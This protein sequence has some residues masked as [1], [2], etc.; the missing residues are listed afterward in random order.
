MTKE[1]LRCSLQMLINVVPFLDH[2]AH[3]RIGPLFCPA[4]TCML[5]EGLFFPHRFVG[6]P[7]GTVYLFLRVSRSACGSGKCKSEP[8]PTGQ[9]SIYWHGRVGVGEELAEGWVISFEV[10]SI[11]ER[12]ASGEEN[13]CGTRAW[14]AHHP[15]NRTEVVAVRDEWGLLRL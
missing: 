4:F 9:N 13:S 3:I 5:H 2:C 10:R 11:F 1:C 8:S 14:R 15:D 6:Q 12:N 7:T